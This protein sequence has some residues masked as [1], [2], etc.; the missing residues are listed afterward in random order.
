MTHHDSPRRRSYLPALLLL[1]LA[2]P[3]P[4]ADV[5]VEA[6]SIST[7]VPKDVTLLVGDT[8]TW[9]RGGGFHNMAADDGT[10]RC[11]SGCDQTGGNGDPSG[12]WTT[13]TFQFVE[14]DLE[15]YECEVHGASG[16]TGTVKVLRA[17]FADGFE[18]GDVTATQWAPLDVAADSCA[19]APSPG[20][21]TDLAAT[22]EG[23]TNGADLT[24][25]GSCLGEA[26]HG[27]DRFF[28]FSLAVGQTLSLTVDTVSPGFDPA[29]YLIPAADC[30]NLVA[31]ECLDA[32]H[33][34]GAGLPETVTYT[35]NTAGPVSLYAVVDSLAAA[36]A[37]SDFTITSVITP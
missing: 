34:G 25:D 15:T 13:A 37:G 3:A 20:Q 2:A 32:A 28:H 11:A 27:R 35:N 9:T 6:T 8:V 14:P 22:L 5:D 10:F 33:A 24:F 31:I 17:V 16:M 21:V 7:F 26:A 19:S 18:D 4:G 30:P 36:V 23:A 29:V 1:G 12:S